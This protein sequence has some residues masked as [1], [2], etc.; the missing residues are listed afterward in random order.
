Y[1][2]W[3]A[4]ICGLHERGNCYIPS[5][6]A[7][8]I[9]VTFAVN[10]DGMV[11]VS[12]Q[13]QENGLAQS[14]RVKISG[15]LAESE[16]HRLAA[17]AEVHAEEDAQARLLLDTSSKADSVLDCSSQLVAEHGES[18]DSQ[19]FKNM[20]NSMAD[21]RSAVQGKGQQ[22]SFNLERIASLTE[23]LQS[24]YGKAVQEVRNRE[25]LALEAP[26]AC[27][28]QE[29]A[30]DA[31]LVASGSEEGVSVLMPLEEETGTVSKEE[32]TDVNASFQPVSEYLDVP[33]A[34]SWEEV[35]DVATDLSDEKE[36]EEWASDLVES[37]DEKVEESGLE[38]KVANAE[39]EEWLALAS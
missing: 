17:E 22:P 10:V 34:G 12:A 13:D 14:M 26:V 24:W 21:L 1:L 32:K 11:N 36:G 15:G 25:V 9:E 7:Q 4:I 6:A 28:G 5:E 19:L 27:T 37:T 31:K 38:A 35:L 16:I 8:R 23:T 33:E 29:G 18:L 39:E 30:S 3:L 20:E 2:R